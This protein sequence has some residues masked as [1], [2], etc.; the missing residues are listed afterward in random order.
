M[1]IRDGEKHKAYLGPP[2]CGDDQHRQA[3][4]TI[5]GLAAAGQ[6]EPIPG[7]DGGLAEGYADIL[8]VRTGG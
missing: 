6:L 8:G 1:A 2:L 3:W 5:Q 7:W 4:K